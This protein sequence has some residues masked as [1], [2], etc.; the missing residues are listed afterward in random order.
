MAMLIV[1]AVLCGI[2]LAYGTFEADRQLEI[3][4]RRE[5]AQ[6]AIETN[7]MNEEILQSYLDDMSVLILD[8]GL[9][10]ETM[11][12][13]GTDVGD[14]DA[15]VIAR[16]RTL[17][18]LSALDGKRNGILLRFLLETGMFELIKAERLGIDLRGAV[19]VEC[20]MSGASLN[21][22]DLREAVLVRTDLSRVVFLDA[23]LRGALLI[24]ANLTEAALFRANLR[25]AHL[26]GANLEGAYY[27]GSTI[28]PEGF[29]A[30]EAGAIEITLE[31][32]IEETQ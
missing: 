2:A 27:D 16:A 10:S 8:Y 28:W 6:S 1:P 13:K 19:I 11:K 18:T 29:D 31:Q 4:S 17:A 30:S 12:G 20:D 21:K 7:R 26:S 22:S 15:R 14:M 5:E 23:D 9:R 25:G 32:W 3:E 24:G